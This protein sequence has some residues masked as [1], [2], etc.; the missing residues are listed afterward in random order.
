MHAVTAESKGAN[1]NESK[2]VEGLAQQGTSGR[3]FCPTAG[4]A[5][6]TSIR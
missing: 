3:G 5:V 6:Y 4:N 1:A 2:S